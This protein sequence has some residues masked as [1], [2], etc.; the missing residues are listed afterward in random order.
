M[1]EVADNGAGVPPEVQLHIS[2]PF[3]TIKGVGKGTG[4][5]LDIAY[6]ISVNK[7][8][9]DLRVTSHVGDTRFQIRLPIARP[10]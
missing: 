10:A 8:H 7:H 5:G 1:V 3:F 4:L 2:E 6:R 9:G